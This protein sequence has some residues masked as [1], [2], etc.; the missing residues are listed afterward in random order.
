[1]QV[2]RL[3]SRLSLSAAAMGLVGMDAIRAHPVFSRY[4]GSGATVVV[5]DQ[6]INWGTG[7]LAARRVTDIDVLGVSG[8]IEGETH[9]TFVASI[10]GAEA[11]NAGIAPGAGI[12]GVLSDGTE[13]PVGTNPNEVWRL[14]ENDIELLLQWVIENREQY[15]IVA[16]NLSLGDGRWYTSSS[17]VAQRVLNDEIAELE[18]DGVFIVAAAGNDYE[19]DQTRNAAY[20]A[21]IST[22]AVGAVYA[23]DVGAQ[24]GNNTTGVDHLAAFSQ[25]PPAGSQNALFAPGA[26]VRGIMGGVTFATGSG[27]SFAAPYVSGAIAILQ[28]AALELSG[29]LMSVDALYDVIMETADTVVDGDDED[30]TVSNTGA[31]FG[32]LNVLAALEEV[33]SRFSEANLR[34]LGG[35]QLDQVIEHE[36]KAKRSNGTGF[37]PVERDGEWKEALFFLRNT[38]T[39]PL[40]IDS[41]QIRGQSPEHFEITLGPQAS[42]EPGMTAAV[43][44]RFDP[45][46]FGTVRA[47]LSVFSSDPDRARF[48]VRIAGVGIPPESAADISAT[49]GPGEIRDGDRR[50]RANTGTKMGVVAIGGAP[51]V[52]IFLLTNRGESTLNLNLAQFAVTGAHASDF[53]IT[54][55]PTFNVLGPGQSTTFSVRFTPSAAG[56][57]KADIVLVSDDPDEGEFSFRVVG[58]GV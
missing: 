14:D 3:E 57:R 47:N 28:Q 36:T 52:R 44:V 15:N 45:E 33:T 39:E 43:V 35:A 37:G 20:P 12:I 24:P 55:D 26:A 18:D 27:T 13:P 8:P 4:D 40:E 30:D 34:V 56:L 31:S 32:R 17:Q 53:V 23:A 50:A 10:V 54:P 16:V 21:I 46:A 38:G 48:T 25:R 49:A 58:T 9:G 5:I 11:A 1:M 22:F 7:Q 51:V 2:E 6:P 29:E 41:V 19:E 42:V